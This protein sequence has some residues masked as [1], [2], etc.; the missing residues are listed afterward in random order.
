MSDHT[1]DPA[2]QLRLALLHV[3]NAVSAADRLAVAHRS[4]RKALQ[5]RLAACIEEAATLLSDVLKETSTR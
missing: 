3:T 1:D 5:D 2:L 4:R